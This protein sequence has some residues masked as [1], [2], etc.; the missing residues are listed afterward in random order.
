MKN[1]D[2]LE[3]TGNLGIYL[4]YD[5]LAPTAQPVTVGD[6]RRW[7]NA[8]EKFGLPDDTELEDCTLSIYINGIEAV[9]IECGEHADGKRTD[10]L[11]VIHACEGDWK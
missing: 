3:V 5:G 7:L 10:A 2:V 9:P 6:V 4:C 1:D 8:C 11:I